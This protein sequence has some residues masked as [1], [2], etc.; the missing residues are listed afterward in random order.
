LATTR[1]ARLSLAVRQ[2]DDL[3]RQASSDAVEQLKVET[4]EAEEVAKGIYDRLGS[5]T[6][7]EH[8][9]WTRSAKL[10][11]IEAKQAA[12]AKLAKAKVLAHDKVAQEAAEVS[13]A[14]LKSACEQ[15][16]TAAAEL[17]ELQEAV[18]KK[19]AELLTRKAEQ[20]VL[21]DEVAAL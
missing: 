1:A 16:A 2:A 8:A 10:K 12:E 13:E 6:V 21:L 17:I 5:I 7:V 4:E 15:Q 18:R 3:V 20:Q 9:E 19:E 11:V 14:E